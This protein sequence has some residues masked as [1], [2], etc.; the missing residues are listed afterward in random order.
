MNKTYPKLLQETWNN[1]LMR[2]DAR[3]KQSEEIA[4]KG[5][6]AL[7]QPVNDRLQRYEEGVAKVEAERRDSFGNNVGLIESMRVGHEKVSSEAAKLVHGLR[8][9]PNSRGRWGEQHD[10]KRDVLGKSVAVRV[11]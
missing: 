8:N 1:F 9:A 5:L 7:L 10:R 2:A 6:K 11:D 3:F 4:G